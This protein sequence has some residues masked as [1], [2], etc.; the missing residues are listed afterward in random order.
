M[1]I[2]SLGGSRYCL[3]VIDD[4]SR[5]IWVVPLKSND[6]TQKHLIKLIKQ[7]QTEKDLKLAKI[8]SDRGTE[9]LNKTLSSFLEEFGIRHEMSSARTPQQNGIAERRNRTL[10]EAA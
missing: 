6:E 5:F 2:T 8:R 9:F 7:I 10:K 4:Y 3:V 1:P